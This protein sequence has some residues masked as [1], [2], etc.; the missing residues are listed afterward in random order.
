MRWQGTSHWKGSPGREGNNALKRLV[1]VNTKAY[2]SVRFA[3]IV[4]DFLIR[5]ND[6]WVQSET[7]PALV[8]FGPDPTAVSTFHTKEQRLFSFWIYLL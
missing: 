7:R 3:L 1:S 8:G 4:I 6:W 2:I 5:I